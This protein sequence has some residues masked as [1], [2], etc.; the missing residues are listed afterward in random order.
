MECCS[1]HRGAAKCGKTVLHL[2]QAGHY[3]SAWSSLTLDDFL[4]WARQKAECT[5]HGEDNQS[6]SKQAAAADVSEAVE[7]QDLLHINVGHGQSSVYSNFQLSQQ[8][9]DLGSSRGFSLDLA[10]K[11][12]TRFSNDLLACFTRTVDAKPEQRCRLCTAHL[13][14]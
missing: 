4:S 5:A 10:G 13:Q 3:G 6:P 1:A 12:G 8:S 11:A 2:D 9:I 7:A 14:Q